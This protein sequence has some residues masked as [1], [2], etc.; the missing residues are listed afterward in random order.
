MR[1]SMGRVRRH[2][3]HDMARQEREEKRRIARGEPPEDNGGCLWLIALPFIIYFGA[4]AWYITIPALI[5]WMVV[6]N[7]GDRK[8]E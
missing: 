6:E 5:I 1:V 8:G 3:Y 7:Y 4:L 2:V